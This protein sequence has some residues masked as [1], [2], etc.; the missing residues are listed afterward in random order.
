M[1]SLSKYNKG[2]K[3]LLCTIDI[4]SKC[5]WVIPFKDKRGT[6]IVNAFQKMINWVK[7]GLIKAVNFT[8]T[9]LKIFWK[10]IILK[11]TQHIMKENLLLLKDLLELWKRRFLSTWQLFQIFFFVVDVLDDIVNKF[12]V[13]RTIKMKPI[14][15]TPNSYVKYNEDSN[16]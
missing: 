16:K 7:Y 11:Y 3:Y 4:F 12:T 5:A 9:L 1:Q 14:D 10:W 2:I 6:S 8:I 13:H 15:V